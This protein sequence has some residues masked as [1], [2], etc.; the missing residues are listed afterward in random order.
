MKRSE[1]ILIWA[2]FSMSLGQQTATKDDQYRAK[3]YLIFPRQAPTRHQFIAGIGI[4][5][6]LDYE[7][8]TVGYVLKAE[9]YL[10]YNESVFRQNPLFPEYK[11]KSLRNVT[12]KQTFIKDGF[13]WQM[14]DLME[15]RIN[16]FGFNGH[17]CLLQIICEV[18]KKTIAQDFSTAAEL[19]FL[20][21]SPSST[22]NSDARY[23]HDYIIA[24][25]EG[26]LKNCS[27]YDC[28]IQIIDLF[29][30]ALKN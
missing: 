26:F 30:F 12:K 13:R 27:K 18:Q 1:W 24:E 3:R 23:A 25:N 22:L 28:N 21:L 20:L 6:D 4:P 2:A 17:A 8:L 10:P 29:S 7:S 9:F 16:S 5:A 14:Y 11:K 15:R 19:L